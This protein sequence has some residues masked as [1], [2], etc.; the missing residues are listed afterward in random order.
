MSDLE[1]LVHNAFAE[2][3]YPK[4]SAELAE[5]R[6]AN[7]VLIMDE[8]PRPVHL[9]QLV[10]ENAQLRKDLKDRTSLFL[11]EQD[12]STQLRAENVDL[13]RK[14]LLLCNQNGE[15][16]MERIQLRKDLEVACHVKAKDKVGFDFAV[17]EEIAICQGVILSLR[18]DLEMERKYRTCRSKILPDRGEAK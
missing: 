16:L 7:D 10:K 1:N 14:G 12:Q 3:Q 15:L 18:K 17:L 9:W 4:A 5:L 2:M 13:M 11:Q 6:K 8:N